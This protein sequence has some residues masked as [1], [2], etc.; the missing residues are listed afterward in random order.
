M[1]N[2]VIIAVA[3]INCILGDLPGNAAKILDCATRAKGAGAQ[4]LVTPELSLCGYPPEDLLLRDGFFRDCAAA[5]DELA[6]ALPAIKVIVGHP[7][8]ANGKRYNAASV[9]QDGSILATYRKR[10]LPN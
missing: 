2:S 5:L 6:A 7:Q 1:N 10:N 4:V 9:L 8:L 3:Q